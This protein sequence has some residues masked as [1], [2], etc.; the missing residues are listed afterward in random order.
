MITESR[1]ACG[2]GEIARRIPRGSCRFFCAAFS[3][4][5]YNFN[6][7]TS[8]YSARVVS[9]IVIHMPSRRR[10][11]DTVDTEYAIARR[12]SGHV[13][14]S[15]AW[16]RELVLLSVDCK[17]RYASCR[18]D[19]LNTHPCLNSRHPSPMP[20]IRTLIFTTRYLNKEK[21]LTLA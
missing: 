1:R 8:G 13:I 4:S 11:A 21:K 5:L 3:L 7:G 14:P 12:G 15:W 20:D 6:R 18:V 17:A 2:L 16:R 19:S 9:S 10:L